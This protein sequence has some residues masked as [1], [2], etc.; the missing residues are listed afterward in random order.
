MRVVK[1][2]TEQNRDLAIAGTSTVVKFKDNY[3]EV[4]DKYVHHFEFHSGYEVLPQGSVISQPEIKT[5]DNSGR[6][7]K[8]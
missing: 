3:A 4:E 2:I 1:D 5:K 6:E 8:E 7:V